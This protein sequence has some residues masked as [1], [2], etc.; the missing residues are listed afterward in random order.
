MIGEKKMIDQN[1][2]RENVGIVL[3]NSKKEFLLKL[4]FF[5]KFF[6]ETE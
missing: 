5:A 1:G 4:I 6:F 2:F 3:V